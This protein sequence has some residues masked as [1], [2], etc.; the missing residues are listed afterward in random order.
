[1]AVPMSSVPEQT[2]TPTI[3]STITVTSPVR[4]HLLT[5]WSGQTFMMGSAPI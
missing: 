1:M 5:A 4:H 2:K 3:N